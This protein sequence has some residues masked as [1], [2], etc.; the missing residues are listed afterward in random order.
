MVVHSAILRVLNRKC[1]SRDN[2]GKSWNRGRRIQC[3]SYVD[4]N[5]QSHIDGLDRSLH[6]GFGQHEFYQLDVRQLFAKC[7]ERRCIRLLS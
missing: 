4:R 2:L 1:A 6:A 5:R 7:R 3:N